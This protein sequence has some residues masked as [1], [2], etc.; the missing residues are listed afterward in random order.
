MRDGLLLAIEA[1]DRATHG[2]HSPW[3]NGVHEGTACEG[4]YLMARLMER[5]H[6]LAAGKEEP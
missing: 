6:V 2:C 3:C 4:D 1:I 5:L